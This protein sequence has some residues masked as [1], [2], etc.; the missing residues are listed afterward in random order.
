MPT[1]FEVKFLNVNHDDVRV[2]LKKLGAKCAHP[3]RLMRRAMFD[4]DDNRMQKNT[5]KKPRLRV[6]DE[7]NK[8]TITYKVKNETN[9]VHEVETIVDSYDDM[10]QILQETGLKV[11]SYQES[12]RETWDYKNVEIV[13]DEWPWLNPYI[14]IEGP[15]E[16]EIK[17]VAKELGFDWKDAAF[18]SVDRAY[19]GQYKGMSKTESIGDVPEVKFDMT[20]PKYLIDRTK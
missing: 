7:G 4:F 15:S 5:D 16:N 12:K 1:E 2:R 19:R 13:L 10:V 18:G 9:Y 17:A 3:M 20:L 14:E 11:F 8:V 6:R